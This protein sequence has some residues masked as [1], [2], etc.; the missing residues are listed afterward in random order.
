MVA[1]VDT[2]DHSRHRPIN[3]ADVISTEPAGKKI[4]VKSMNV[5]L[6]SSADALVLHEKHLRGET[7]DVYPDAFYIPRKDVDLSKFTKTESVTYCPY[8]GYASYYAYNGQEVAWSYETP[9]D[10]KKEI[11]GHLAFYKD[12]VD[13]LS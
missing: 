13:I 2:N 10:Q 5:E 1:I 7:F 3:D 12:R 6:A 11:K 9:Y 8:K 4:V